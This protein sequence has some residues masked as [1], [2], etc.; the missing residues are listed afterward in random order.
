MGRMEHIGQMVRRLAENHQVKEQ[1]FLRRFVIRQVL[2]RSRR[3]DRLNAA[4]A[5]PDMLNA[6]L[7]PDCLLHMAT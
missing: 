5:V 1:R 3:S 7:V 2:P 4:D 6:L